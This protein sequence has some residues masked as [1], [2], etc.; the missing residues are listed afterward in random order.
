MSAH[1][2]GKRTAALFAIGLVCVSATCLAGQRGLPV[3]EGIVNFGKVSDILYRG[4]Q[5]DAA[6]LRNLR[7]L[8]VKT[9]IDLRMRGEVLKTEAEEAQAN[10]L[11]YTNVP[12]HGLG[13]PTHAQVK[14]VL[15]LIESSPSPV[16]IHCEHGCDRTGTIIACYRIRHDRWSSEAA[17]KEARQYGLSRFE[18][19]MR[20]YI[21]YFEKAPP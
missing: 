8:G 7:C 13:R 10:G 12:M 9:V 1:K 4:A 17:L 15:A 6:A 5:P 20:S 14:K 19:G 16:F 21:M 11:V 2:L 18:R 3:K